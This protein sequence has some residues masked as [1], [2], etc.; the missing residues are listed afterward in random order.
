MGFTDSTDSEGKA[1]EK[2]CVLRR[3]RVAQ[4]PFD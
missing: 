4:L 1:N 3:Q 2:M